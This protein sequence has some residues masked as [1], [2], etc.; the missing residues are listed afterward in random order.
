VDPTVEKRGNMIGPSSVAGR[1]SAVL[2]IVDVQERLGAVMPRRA[3]VLDA[4]VK[5]VRTAAIVGVPVMA[6]RQY[7]AGLGDVEPVLRAALESVE[8]TTP[9]SHVDKVAFDCF[10][11]PAFAEAVVAS[12]RKQLVIVGMETHI[13]VTQTALTALRSGFDVHVVADACCSRDAGMHDIAL[14]RMRVAGVVVTTA[15]SVQ[16][17]L[18]GVADTD[19]FRALLRIVKE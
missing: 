18:V 16:Y 11:E 15:E 1:D 12:G 8:A 14:E 2:V 6:T 17:E 5:L 7:P 13:C 3:S 9:V 10:A 4:A 19:E